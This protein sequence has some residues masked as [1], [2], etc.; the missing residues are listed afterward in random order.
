[1]RNEAHLTADLARNLEFH[2]G[3]TRVAPAR[4]PPVGRAAGH[5]ITDRRTMSV[6]ILLTAQNIFNQ[7]PPFD[8]SERGLASALG[9]PR[10]STYGITVSAAF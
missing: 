8:A 4:R 9:D 1:M 5:V 7:R 2:I 6:T 3:G 10:M